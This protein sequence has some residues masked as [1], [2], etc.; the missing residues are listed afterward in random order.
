MKELHYFKVVELRM[1]D[2]NTINGGCFFLDLWDSIKKEF[3]E[4]FNDGSGANC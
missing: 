1:E 3:R 2:A 4:G